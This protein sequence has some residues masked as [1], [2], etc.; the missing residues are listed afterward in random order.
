[1]PSA[2]PDLNEAIKAAA[3]PGVYEV[4]EWAL[5]VHADTMEQLNKS[6]VDHLTQHGRFSLVEREEA[7]RILLDYGAGK[8]ARIIEHRGNSKK[9]ILFETRVGST[10]K[11]L[12]EPD[13][14]T[15]DA[16]VLSEGTDNT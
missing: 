8:P 5:Q 11:Q 14:Q 4:I 7:R 15:I 3:E 9:P 1:M 6:Y 16:E 10:V 2:K 12:K 13:T